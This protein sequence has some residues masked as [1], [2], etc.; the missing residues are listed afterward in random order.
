MC[1]QEIRV[2]PVLLQPVVEGRVADHGKICSEHHEGTRTELPLA[3]GACGVLPLPVEEV[4]HVL[5]G[6]LV[7]RCGPRTLK[8]APV[9]VA[10]PKGVATSNE[11]HCLLVVHVHLQECV[12]DLG[13]GARLRIDVDDSGVQWLALSAVR[14]IHAATTETEGR[15]AHGLNCSVASQDN[16]VSPGE[17]GA[18]SILDRL[19]DRKH[20]VQA[21]IVPPAV[22][23]V[24]A[25]PCTVAAPTPV[26][27]PVGASAMPRQAY[28]ERP[29]VAVVRTC[30]R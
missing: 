7:W 15:A 18:V 6:P 24:K 11:R 3:C 2:L 8:A 28:H 4:C 21:R 29:V 20:L 26:C 22:L 10:T 5:V 17:R 19:Q 1:L 13:R 14:G 27:S 23:R 12:P 25:D 16:K 30:V 9:R